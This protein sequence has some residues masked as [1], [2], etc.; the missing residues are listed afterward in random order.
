MRDSLRRAFVRLA[1][2][3]EQRREVLEHPPACSQA[4]PR[5]R[6]PGDESFDASVRRNIGRSAGMADAA[7]GAERG[8]ERTI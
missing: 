1:Y 2:A 6:H 3:G 7:L 4:I 8:V 5:E